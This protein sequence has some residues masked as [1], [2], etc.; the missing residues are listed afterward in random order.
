MVIETNAL[1]RD[2]GTGMEIAEIL[3]E[4]GEDLSQ[5][6]GLPRRRN[7]LWIINKKVRKNYAESAQEFQKHF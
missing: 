3:A 2:N 5:F 7:R 1:T 6:K 4:G